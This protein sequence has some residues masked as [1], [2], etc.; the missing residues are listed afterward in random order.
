M[1]CRPDA[2]GRIAVRLGILPVSSLPNV[3]GYRFSQFRKASARSRLT[4]I[5]SAG[6]GSRFTLSLPL[7]CLW[8][9]LKLDA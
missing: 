3:T 2:V 8:M 9:V 6:A 4:I 1:F 7:K 5:G